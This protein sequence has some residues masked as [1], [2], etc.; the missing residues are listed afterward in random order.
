M[1]LFSVQ[2]PQGTN[3]RISLPDGSQ[4]WLN[5]GSTLSYRSDFNH[6]SRDIGLSGEAYFEVARNADL[7]FRGAG[8]GLHVH[9]TG[10]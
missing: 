6:S 7:P 1:Q 3:S 5:A 8:P 2:A 10:H 9:R 4:V